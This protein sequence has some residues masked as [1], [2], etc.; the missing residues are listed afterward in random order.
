MCGFHIY[1]NFLMKFLRD[2]TWPVI[3]G[4]LFNL[5]FKNI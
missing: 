1:P 2:L 3:G 5:L 4:P